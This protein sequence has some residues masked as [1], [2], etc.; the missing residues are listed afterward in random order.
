[1]IDFLL[2]YIL[3]KYNIDLVDIAIELLENGKT[4][5]ELLVI[6]FDLFTI[7]KAKDIIN[8]YGK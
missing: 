4:E 3:D 5:K 7:I 8:S 6:G 2:D 1:M